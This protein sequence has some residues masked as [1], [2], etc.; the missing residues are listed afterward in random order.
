M[1]AKLKRAL[2]AGNRPIWITRIINRG[3]AMIH[4]SG[5]APN[6]L[7]TLEVIGRKSG[8]TISLP[9]AVALMDGE[10]YLVSMLG[11]EA[12]WVLNV[13]AADGKAHIRAGKRTEV[14]LEEVPVDQRAPIIKKYLQ[15]AP[16]ARPHIPVNKD[17]PIESFVAIADAYPV[18]RIVP[19]TATRQD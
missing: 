11:N 4:S 12:Q 15:I 10:R 13:R 3:W 2:Y 18:F 9:V 14:R 5:I 8:K 1:F 17:M 16:G 6:W 7:L 19:I